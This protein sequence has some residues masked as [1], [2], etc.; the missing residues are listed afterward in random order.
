MATRTG[1]LREILLDC[2]E[3]VRNRKMD[4]QEAAAVAK[5]AAQVTLSMQVELNAKRDALLPQGTKI[6][7]LPLGDENTVTV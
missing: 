6:G 3:R 2:I 7:A 4:H 5:L 1:E